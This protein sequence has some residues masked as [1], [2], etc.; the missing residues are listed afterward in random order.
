[1]EKVE[2]SDNELEAVFRR[3]LGK[4][5]PPRLSVAE[6]RIAEKL[7]G[8]ENAAVLQ[9]R[10]RNGERFRPKPVVV[11]YEYW[12]VQGTNFSMGRW[13]LARMENGRI[14]NQR[15]LY[16]G[17]LEAHIRE[18][19]RKGIDVREFKV[20]GAPAPASGPKATGGRK[21]FADRY[22]PSFMKR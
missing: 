14:T 3:N 6:V 22:G 7:L 8:R 15:S 1:M 4:L 18:L 21:S 16:D 20:D 2:L 11:K 13:E 9:R 12:W 19:R 5:E 10:V 17:E